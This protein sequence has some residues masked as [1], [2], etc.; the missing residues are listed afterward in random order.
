MCEKTWARNKA[1]LEGQRMQHSLY[2][3][4]QQDEKRFQGLCFFIIDGLLVSRQKEW[5]QG[6]RIF[7][8]IL[9]VLAT[10]GIRLSRFAWYIVEVLV[11]GF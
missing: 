1:V 3:R 10:L 9:N 4:Q 11:F 2:S 6:C 7:D 5:P 8:C